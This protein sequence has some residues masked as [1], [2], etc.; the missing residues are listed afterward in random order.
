MTIDAR[1]LICRNP[2]R[3]RLVELGWNGGMSAEAIA[4][5]LDQKGAGA[6]AIL[7]H[8]KQH[9]EG[10]GNVRAVVVE[11]EKSPAERVADLQRLQLDEFE[12]R[13]ELAKAKADRMNAEHADDEK[14]EPVD[15]SNFVDIL[16]KDWQA[17]VGS[18]LKAQ[19]L[20]D[21]RDMKRDD[22]KLGLFEAMARAGLAPK[23]I[24]GTAAIAI[25]AEVGED[26]A[27]D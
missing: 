25:P 16:G 27:S 24:S 4:R 12:R 19:G 23:A 9:A 5:V 14:W 26:D 17:A 22:L 21:K 20:K 18:I 10:D 13:I 11:P 6:Q 2:D 1:C 3:R 15:W 8:L 7:S